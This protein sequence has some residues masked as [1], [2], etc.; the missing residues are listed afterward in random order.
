[1]FH[2][3]NVIRL[4]LPALR[5][6]LQE[7]L[8]L[9]ENLPALA[10]GRDDTQMFGSDSESSMPSLRQTGDA[11]LPEPAGGLPTRRG[12]TQRANEED[13]PQAIS[14]LHDE[15]DDLSSVAK[16]AMAGLAKEIAVKSEDKESAEE[17]GRSI[18]ELSEQLSV[19]LEAASEKS[20]EAVELLAE[21]D[22]HKHAR[23][24]DLIDVTS[25][26][27]GISS[28]GDLFSVL[29]EHNT[30]VPA[31]KQRVFTTNQDGQDAVQISVRQG[32]AEKASQNQLLG[33]FILEGIRPAQRME[34]KI[35]VSFVI[36][37]NG[38]L[39]VSARDQETD[40]AQSI[41]VEDPLGLQQSKPEDIER[42]ERE[43]SAEAEAA[44]AD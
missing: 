37:E 20:E 40:A 8:A 26:A 10:E 7:L 25:L 5:E 27:L 39:A 13:F 33:E 36:D 9:A 11:D 21:A 6:R 28:A 24:V 32:R 17:I 35:E 42:I 43:R 3:L 2:R 44:E 41:R 14:N 15:L 34:P 23:R 29:I 30:R 22:V 38:I 18:E 31:E 16:R 4:R 12:S 1:M 19:G